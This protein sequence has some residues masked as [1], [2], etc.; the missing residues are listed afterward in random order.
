MRSEPIIP[1]PAHSQNRDQETD[2][3]FRRPMSDIHRAGSTCYMCNAP[4][5]CREHVPP[6]CIFPPGP[7]LRTN[8][9]KVP[10]CDAHNLR[11]SKD[12]ELLRHILACA[13]G[14]NELALQVVERGVMRAFDRR[15]HIVDTFLPNLTPIQIGD[16]ESASFTIDIPRFEMSIQAIV[17]GLFFADTGK[18][19]LVDLRVVWGVLLTPDL[20]QVPFFEVIERAE[21]SLPP[22]TRGTNPR[23]FQYD[24][25][26]SNSK[27]VRVCRL[28][29]FEGHPIYVTW[30]TV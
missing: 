29:F 8:L 21:R 7:R 17:R 27:T 10:S 1:T 22:V 25:N 3:G 4:A 20:S 14:N 16:S 18:K 6:K 2:L 24:F 30:K 13:P 11:K 26:E 12:D 23:V 5:T 9:V 19:L 15:P 28:R